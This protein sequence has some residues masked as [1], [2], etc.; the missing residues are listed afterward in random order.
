MILS[1]PFEEN[2]IQLIKNFTT[3]VIDKNSSFKK[4]FMRN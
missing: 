2:F 4:H 1:L 3:I